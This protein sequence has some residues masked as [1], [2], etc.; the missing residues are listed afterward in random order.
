MADGLLTRFLK[1]WRAEPRP[2]GWRR[3]LAR[4]A[5]RMLAFNVLV[6]FLPIAGLFYLGTYAE[7]LLEAQER[8]MVQ[9]GRLLAAAL[10]AQDTFDDAAVGR[11]LRD[12]NGR[13]DARLRIIA[14][15]G[16]VLGDT[17]APQRAGID[18]DETADASANR[19]SYASLAAPDAAAGARSTP[20]ATASESP[21][22]KAA[23]ERWLYRLGAAI[24]HAAHAARAML[25]SGRSGSA[26]AEPV[27][28][29]DPQRVLHAPE[30]QAALAGRYGSATRLTRGQRSVTLYSAIPIRR[31]DTVIGAVLV[32]ESTYR[33]LQAL[34]DVRLRIFEVI[35]S[36]LIAAALLSMIVAATIARPLRRLQVDA[37]TVL[38][39]RG[40][41]TR[42]FRGT[43]RWDEIGDLARALEALTTRFDQHLRFVESFS[44]DL[45]H[46]FKN[47]LASIRTVADI[48][49]SIEDPQERQRFV[50]RLLRDLTRLERLLA[51]VQ[52]IVSIDTQLERD[53]VARVDLNALLANILDAH[54]MRT[55]GAIRLQLQTPPGATLHVRASPERLAQVF[56]N[57]VDN[58][59]SFSPVNG[60]VTVTLAR[61]DG[62]CRVAISDEGPGIPEAHLA[63]I[64]E[65]FFTYRPV[66]GNGSN[67]SSGNSGSINGSNPRDRHTGLG[68]SIALAIVESYG[69]TIDASNRP[70]GGAVLDVT[71]P[72]M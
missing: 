23:R 56:D 5:F 21:E 57:L 31:G 14:A 69:G 50:D 32:S 19:S 35:V 22:S 64:F 7:H 51:G 18:T 1:R 68:L 45:S 15:D 28:M 8:G 34:Y 62:R 46:E 65:R 29:R 2:R 66:G 24:A 59:V 33:L 25:P 58:A 47:P 54:R 49:G 44:A 20:S 30:I 9:Q 39:H 63:R 67:S 3:Q 6:V 42:G 70:S 11:L 37:A 17:S 4:I 36:S 38:D 55:D 61:Q 13:V 71:L 41:L 72:A 16:H 43:A 27:D 26:I 10:A 12:L 60:L 48:L 40:R 53:P 52:E